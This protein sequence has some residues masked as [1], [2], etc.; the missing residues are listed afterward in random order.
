MTTS[1][2]SPNTSADSG[3][4]LVLQIRKHLTGFSFDVAFSAGPG[5]T[6]LFGP[7]GAGRTTVLDLIAGL[8]R[9]DEGT[10]SIDGCVLFDSQDK[11]DVPAWKRRVGYVLQ[12]L[13]L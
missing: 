8:S 13:A 7:S 9:P 1:G 12:D 11:Q 2:T 4:G 6:I 10:I 3:G 5:F